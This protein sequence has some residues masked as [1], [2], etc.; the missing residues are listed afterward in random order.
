[1]DDNYSPP[2]GKQI[3]I[4]I[5]IASMI[6]IAMRGCQTKAPDYGCVETVTPY[7]TECQ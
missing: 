3:L 1:M 5:A 2:T 4:I 6:G 7:G